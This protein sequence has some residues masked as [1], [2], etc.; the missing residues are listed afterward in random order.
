MAL[1]IVIIKPIDKEI[2]SFDISKERNMFVAS[3]RFLSNVIKEYGKHPV[4]TDGGAWYPPQAC[5]FLKLVYHHSFFLSR[6]KALLKE[7]C[8]T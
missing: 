7:Q 6:K 5:R 1:M 3:E 8:S 4:S 2:L